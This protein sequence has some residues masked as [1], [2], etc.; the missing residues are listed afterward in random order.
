M[1]GG[2][3]GQAV[4]SGCKLASNAVMVSSVTSGFAVDALNCDSAGSQYQRARF[5]NA[6]TLT[7]ETTIVRTGG[8]SIEGTGISDKIVTG[9]ACSWAAPFVSIPSVIRNGT[10]AGNVTVTV[11]GIAPSGGLPNNDQVW[12]EVEYPGA[13][14][15]P[16]ATILSTT[17]ANVLSSAAAVTSDASTWGGAGAAFKLVATLTSPQ[18]QLAGTILVRVKVGKPSYTVYFDPLIVLS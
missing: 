12:I 11:Y 9:S 3:S 2:G 15:S 13:T 18:P 7:T 16:L 1:A 8:A 14:G 4:L 10:T 6:G 5:A 17:K